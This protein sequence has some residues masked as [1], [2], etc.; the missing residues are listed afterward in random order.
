MGCSPVPSC[1]T[2]GAGACQTGWLDLHRI[3]PLARPS[4]RD[5]VLPGACQTCTYPELGSFC[6]RKAEYIQLNQLIDKDLR[7]ISI[8][9]VGLGGRPPKP[10]TDPDLR[11]IKPPLSQCLIPDPGR[12]DIGDQD[13][14][15]DNLLHDDVCS[16]DLLERESA[17]SFH[18]RRRS[19]PSAQTT[20]RPRGGTCRE[21]TQPRIA[22][23][24]SLSTG[25]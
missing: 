25:I 23:M 1:Q 9:R 16:A 10:P 15:T 17:M 6:I 14:K 8:G 20:H 7:I 12:M 22:Q 24:R 18:S 11:L 3:R 21:R 4:I 2:P 13:L 19:R 5:L